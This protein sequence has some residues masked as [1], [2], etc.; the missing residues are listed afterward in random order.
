[1]SRNDLG[2]WCGVVWCGVV[3]C[4]VVSSGPVPWGG[5]GGV[6]HPPQ[7]LILAIQSVKSNFRS[8]NFLKIFVTSTRYIVAYT[9]LQ[10]FPGAGPACHVVC[11]SVVVSVS[12]SVCFT[13]LL[14]PC[15]KKFPAFPWNCMWRLLRFKVHCFRV[16][17]DF[18]IFIGVKGTDLRILK[19]HQ[20]LSIIEC[21]KL[22]LRK[23]NAN[24]QSSF[25]CSHNSKV[26]SLSCDSLCCSFGKH[27]ISEIQPRNWMSVQ[28]D[29]WILASTSL[30]C[31]YRVYST[32]F[33][34]SSKAP[35]GFEAV[36]KIWRRRVLQ[37]PNRMLSF[38]RREQVLLNKRKK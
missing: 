9:P 12:V 23:R 34:F 20:D 10:K 18:V 37:L 8:V 2:V 36:F 27:L 38:M 7:R 16:L 32:S 4:D 26:L 11:V 14:L 19:F 21:L 1:M 22:N 5:C 15:V 31:C 29:L 24:R 25:D 6:W 13:L 35:F 3:W 33:L 17:V 30:S 28:I